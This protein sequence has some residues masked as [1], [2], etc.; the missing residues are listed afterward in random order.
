MKDDF[1]EEYKALE[2]DERISD[3]WEWTKRKANENVRRSIQMQKGKCE[4][5]V[6]FHK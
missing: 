1:Y 6:H 4:L 2:D 5:L 3:C